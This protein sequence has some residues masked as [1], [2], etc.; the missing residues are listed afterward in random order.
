MRTTTSRCK[1]CSNYTL[2]QP[3]EGW[4]RSVLFTLHTVG[5]E[6]VWLLP[7]IAGQ[8]WCCLGKHPE[9]NANTQIHSQTPVHVFVFDSST[10]G[11]M[12]VLSASPVL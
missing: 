7:P 2:S 8:V 4:T 3:F 6:G 11:I 10:P 12:G 9:P 1:S 5:P